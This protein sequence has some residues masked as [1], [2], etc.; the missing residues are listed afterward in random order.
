MKILFYL[1]LQSKT[2]GS[3]FIKEYDMKS[4]LLFTPL[5]IVT[6]FFIYLVRQIATVLYTVYTGF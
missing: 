3:F 4:R 5:N 1:L 2:I 6:P